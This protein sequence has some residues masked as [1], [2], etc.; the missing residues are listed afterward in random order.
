M[1][2]VLFRCHFSERG[3]RSNSG[4]SNSK[5]L[6]FVIA[7]AAMH[8]SKRDFYVRIIVKVLKNWLKAKY[9][10]SVEGE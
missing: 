8:V 3:Q 9:R 7:E 1:M 2:K 4:D 6:S 5:S 10:N